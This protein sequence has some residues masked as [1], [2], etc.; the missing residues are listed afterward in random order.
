MAILGSMTNAQEKLSRVNFQGNRA[1]GSREPSPP[2][3][4]ES[5]IE[6]DRAYSRRDQVAACGGIIKDR[7]GKIVEGFQLKLPAGDELTAELWG[8][9]M[10]LKRAWDNGFRKITLCSDSQQAL[11]SIQDEPSN[12][13]EDYQLIME[14]KKC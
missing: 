6:V 13:H 11:S 7:C 10:G 2:N 9:L 4:S 14:I 12:L 8:C 3:E 5:S 1:P